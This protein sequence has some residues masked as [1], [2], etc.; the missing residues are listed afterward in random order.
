LWLLATA[1]AATLSRRSRVG[2][3][4]RDR[5]RHELSITLL[6]VFVGLASAI[7]EPGCIALLEDFL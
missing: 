2:H 5:E 4:L 6:V 3:R 1:G 7:P